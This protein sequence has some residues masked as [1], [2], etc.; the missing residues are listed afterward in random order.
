MRHNEG[1]V[2]RPLP[3]RPVRG[4]DSGRPMMAALDLFGRRW[5]LRIVWE[6]RFGKSRFSDLRNEIEGI[7]SSTLSQRLSELSAA[8]IVTQ[9]SDGAYRLSYQGKALLIALG[10]LELW[11]K[12]WAK[13]VRD[14]APED[15][16]DR[17]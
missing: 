12:A 16:A 11:A 7:S 10:P 6:L 1:E 8:H 2:D 15:P 9:T 13:A 3:G 4:S 14:G 5:A 17:A